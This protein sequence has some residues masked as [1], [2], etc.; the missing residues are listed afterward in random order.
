MW[1]WWPFYPFEYNFFIILT[2]RQITW[3]WKVSLT[4]LRVHFLLFIGCESSCLTPLIPI[5]QYG[6]AHHS[7]GFLCEGQDIVV[8]CMYIHKIKSFEIFCLVELR[9]TN[10]TWE[11]RQ[12][13]LWVWGQC[14][15]QS[16]SKSVRATQRNTILTPRKGIINLSLWVEAKKT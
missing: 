4:V 8:F 12:V 11:E 2:I 6:S 1:L 5:L 14:G 3:I 13:D 9:L 15:L 16:S 10:M 7:K